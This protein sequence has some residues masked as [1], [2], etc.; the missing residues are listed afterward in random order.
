M[1]R[2]KLDRIRK[3]YKAAK[4]LHAESTGLLLKFMQVEKKMKE[5]RRRQ[6]KNC[7][8]HYMLVFE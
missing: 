4:M 5:I 1:R 3:H 2:D 7:A 8:Y 6:R